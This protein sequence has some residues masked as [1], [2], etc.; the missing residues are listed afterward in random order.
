MKLYA[1]IFFI[2]FFG[3]G[4][5]IS[6]A[7]HPVAWSAQFSLPELTLFLNF[8][9]PYE[10]IE[11]AM[12]EEWNNHSDL[13]TWIYAA[14]I[15][16]SLNPHTSGQWDTIPGKGYVWRIGIHAERALSLNLFI[17]NYRMQ[18]GMALYV[19]DR[20][21]ENIAGPF[22][23]R[24][25]ANGGVLPV[26]SLPGDMLVVE[27]NIPVHSLP[28]NDFTITSIGYGFRDAAAN[29]RMV[30]LAESANCNVDVNCKTGNHWQ[31]EQ[32]SVVR[33]ET[34]IRTGGVTRTQ[35]C[36]GTLINQAVDADRKKPYILTAHHCIST[37]ELARATTFVFGYENPHCEGDKPSVPAGITGSSLIATKRDLDF[38][39]VELSNN[40]A[41]E[42]RPYFAGWNT[43]PDAPQGVTGIHHPQGDVKKMSLETDPLVT[44]TFNDPG[45]NL[46]CVENAHW[47][48]RHWEKGITEAG[49]SGS[50]IFDMEHKI[51]GILSGGPK[52]SCTDGLEKRYDFY[53]KFSEQWNRNPVAGE[54]LKSWLDPDAKGITSLWGYDP[55]APYEGRCDTLGHIGAKETM[56]LIESGRWGYLTS[57]NDQRWTGFAEKIRNDSI[58][59]IIGMEVHVAKISGAGSKVQFAIWRGTNFPVAPPL[60]RIDTIVAAD[61]INYP[62]HIYFDKALDITG[63][64][65]VGYNLEYSNP[66]DTFAVYQSAKR[67]YAGI[68]A[69]YVEERSGIWMALDEYVPPVY[70]SLG[71]RVMGRFGKK[72]QP[73]FPTYRDLTIVS[74]PENPVVFVFFE[75]PSSTVRVECYDISGKLMAIKENNRYM[76]MYDEKIYL[77]VE[78]DVGDLPPGMYLIQA[79]DKKNKQS[80]KF[81]RL[82]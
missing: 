36:T 3:Y 41:S 55:C 1:E 11:Q 7:Q 38:T 80:G 18:P 74:Q 29:G 68:S 6:H 28:R 14:G 77:Q 19:Y 30:P 61:Y 54:N 78:I 53:S 25:N 34:I 48:V 65:F 51:V 73:N 10:K 22:D 35:Y 37:N 24:N 60:F 49:S 79:F 43:S 67:P 15:E 75:D 39:L 21:M 62:M 5:A 45:T 82:Y 71:V 50:A 56:M 76:V 27:W 26:Q 31:R 33:M 81:V 70:S 59:N 47:R 20:S 66:I 4:M 9:A 58:A 17:E 63:D 64:F 46:Y 8:S 42:H 16:T 23:V 57:Q 44:S 69:M 12:E 40:I 72:S 52:Y 13:K 2:I 32:R